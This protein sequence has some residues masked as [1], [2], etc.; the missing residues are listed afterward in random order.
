MNSPDD[1]FIITRE[2]MNN[3]NEWVAG[4]VRIRAILLDLIAELRAQHPTE[5]FYSHSEQRDY[6]GCNACTNEGEYRC[7]DMVTMET[8]DPCPTLLELDKAE[9][10]LKGLDHE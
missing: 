6:I 4:Y 2:A 3:F 7:V 1:K 5:T 10:R 8:V 9:A